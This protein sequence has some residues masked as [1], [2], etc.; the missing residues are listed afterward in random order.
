MGNTL[1]YLHSFTLCIRTKQRNFKRKTSSQQL[2]NINHVNDGFLHDDDND[3]KV[4]FYK[5]KRHISNI[6]HE[7][8]HAF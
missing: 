3:E 6:P 7:S 8:L 1:S 5:P 2:K 4:I